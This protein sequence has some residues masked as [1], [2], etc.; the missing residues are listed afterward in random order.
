[1][2][3]T[4]EAS[5]VCQLTGKKANNAFNVTFSHKRNKKLQNAN[6]QY[7]KVYWPEAQR[8][9]K[10]KVSTKALKT[11]EKKGLQIM[12]KE[13]GLDLWKLPYEDAR[14]E[15]LQYL[16]ST[17]QHPPMPKNPRRM[18]N[19][20]KL[21]ASKKG[22]LVARYVFGKVQYIRADAAAAFDAGK[23]L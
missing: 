23:E 10:L 2:K 14:P 20:E 21:A 6:L 12:A 8:Y 17:P 5:K 11:I 22:P 19:P 13:A 7:K 4:V 16:A 3:L 1:M 9:V 15:R 18:K